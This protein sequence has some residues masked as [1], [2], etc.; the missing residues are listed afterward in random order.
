MWPLCEEMCVSRGDLTWNPASLWITWAA[1]RLVAKQFL[2]W[3]SGVAGSWMRGGHCF[4][5]LLLPV[6]FWFVAGVLQRAAPWCFAPLPQAPWRYTAG[7]AETGSHGVQDLDLGKENELMKSHLVASVL[8]K[9]LYTRG[10][11]FYVLEKHLVASES[12]I[13]CPYKW[14]QLIKS[15]SVKTAGRL[16]QE[17]FLTTSYVVR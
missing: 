6:L 11:G 8:Y 10:D 15:L 4:C 17:L 14:M 5:I 16:R 13:S 12:I 1:W 3:I 7:L 9:H 2:H